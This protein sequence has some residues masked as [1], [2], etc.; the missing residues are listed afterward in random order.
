MSHYVSTLL[1]YTSLS[2]VC[3]RWGLPID[4]CR[5]EMLLPGPKLANFDEFFFV[6]KISCQYGG[7]Y[8]HFLW[9][10]ADRSTWI[11]LLFVR[12]AVAYSH[13][14]HFS[15]MYIL[16]HCH[17]AWRCI[18]WISAR[19]IFCIIHCH[20]AWRCIG[21]STCCSASSPYIPLRPPP[22]MKPNLLFK[23]QILR[24]ATIIYV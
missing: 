21:S 5:S 15:K 11:T 8:F 6:A 22:N 9:P 3:T 10:W 23:I 20:L 12:Q 19:C 13:D 2:R 18:F 14:C 16:H 24:I 4:G 7:P 17:L 1:C